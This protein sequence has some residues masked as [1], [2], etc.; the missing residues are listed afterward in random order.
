MWCSVAWKTNLLFFSMT[1]CRLPNT[2]WLEAAPSTD[3]CYH[4]QLYVL[5]HA[6]QVRWARKKNQ[7]KLRLMV[8]ILYSIFRRNQHAV[9]ELF[10]MDYPNFSILKMSTKRAFGVKGQSYLEIGKLCRCHIWTLYVLK[11]YYCT[12]KP[13]LTL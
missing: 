5:G 13:V 6:C 10:H 8:F 9:M 12:G 1:W 4:S 2:G 3:N 7:R 11:Y